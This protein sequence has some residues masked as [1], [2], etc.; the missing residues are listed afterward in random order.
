MKNREKH[1]KTESNM[2]IIICSIDV[3]VDLHFFMFYGIS[4]RKIKLLPVVWVSKIP[5][6]AASMPAYKPHTYTLS[7][8]PVSAPS[9]NSKPVTARS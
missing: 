3:S 4:S 8:T 6:V 9:L 2:K 1:G 5:A 7:E